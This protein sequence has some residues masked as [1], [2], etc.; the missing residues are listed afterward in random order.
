MAN[1]EHDV[2]RRAS[3]RLQST[4]LGDLFNLRMLGLSCIRAW[5]YMLFLGN[6]V[7]LVSWNHTPVPSYVFTVSIFTLVATLFASAVFSNTFIKLMES[8][9]IKIA[10]LSLCTL[11]T[12]GIACA[13]LFP[14]DLWVGVLGAV[15][16]GIGSAIADLGYGASYRNTPGN[17]TALEVPLAFLLASV[18]YLATAVLPGVGTVLVAMALPVVGNLILVFGLGVWDPQFKPLAIPRSINKGHF[19][20][21]IGVCACLVGIADGVVRST[22]VI[23]TGANVSDFFFLPTMLSM[24]IATVVIY[25]SL[26]FSR[27]H[28]CRSAYR[29]YVI[30]MALFFMALPILD[31]SNVLQNT[32]AITGYNTFNALSWILLAEMTYNYRLSSFSTFGIGWGMVSLGVL[33]GSVAS[34]FT[35]NFAPFTPQFLSMVVLCSTVL[36]LCSYLFVL[37]ESDLNVLTATKEE[38]ADMHSHVEDPFDDEG[39]LDPDYL[40]ADQADLFIQGE[41]PNCIGCSYKACASNCTKNAMIQALTE[42]TAPAEASAEQP[43]L[44]TSVDFDKRCHQVA[45]KFQLTGREEEI[46]T[47]YVKGRSSARIQEQLFLTRSTVSTHLRHIYQKMEIHSKQE[48]LD[49]IDGRSNKA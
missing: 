31:G 6:A 8:T 10:A 34:D 5:V 24:V 37:K 18:I 17:K 39:F 36:V 44:K 11:G 43:E 47:L 25:A 20:W 35:N 27:D 7:S 12:A 22:F 4:S 14:F 30:V 46:M 48:L 45:Q 9:G 2:L 32:L 29:F 21:R 49:I 26:L 19:A 13:S 28:T 42:Q 3:Q 15:A 41:D 33:M 23:Q 1:I 38:L 16:T 40:D